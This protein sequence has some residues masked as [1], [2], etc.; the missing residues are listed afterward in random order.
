MELLTTLNSI[1]KRNVVGH[2]GPS[3]REYDWLI[4]FHDKAE[5]LLAAFD[6]ELGT[7]E[8]GVALNMKFGVKG[9][10]GG[11]VCVF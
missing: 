9:G 3:L 2:Q 11:G 4:I 1:G 7:E 8:V 5:D 6:S 10:I